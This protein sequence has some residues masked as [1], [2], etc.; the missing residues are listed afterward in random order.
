MG[1]VWVASLLSNYV[2]TVPQ[3][4]QIEN[5]IASEINLPVQSEVPPQTP[6]P[7]SLEPLVADLSG[8]FQPLFKWDLW[9]AVPD[10]SVVPVSQSTAVAYAPSGSCFPTL[11]PT[12]TQQRYQVWLHDVLIGET[13]TAQKAHQIASKLRQLLSSDAFSPQTIQPLLGDNYAAVGSSQKILFVIDDGFGLPPD[14]HKLAAIYWTNNLRRAFDLPPMDLSQAQMA[15]L[16]VKETQQRFAGIASWYGPN[17]HGRLTATGETFNQ[18]ALTA[19]H[20]SLPFGT[21]LRVR[22]QLN[23]QSV[24]VRVNDRGPY[25]GDRSLDLS[26]AA[27]QCLGSEHV[28]VVPYEAT[29]LETGIPADWIAQASP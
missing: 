22:N 7:E 4:D 27:A 11:Q 8:E 6:P 10:V 12:A 24:V 1:L 23:G 19:A 21:Y 5:Q 16:G 29:I 3:W 14:Q 13:T 20:P 26:Y 17:F 9:A 25:I 18:H 15:A 2:S 28:G